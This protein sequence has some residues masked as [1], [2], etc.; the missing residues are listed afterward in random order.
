MEGWLEKNIFKEGTYFR[1]LYD[2]GVCGTAPHWHSE[3]EIIYILEGGVRAGINSHIYDL[4]Q[5]D[6]FLIG[7]GDSHYF[8]PVKGPGKRIV[9]Q[10][11]LSIFDIAEQEIYESKNIKE[12]FSKVKKVSCSWD[13]D[14]K[15]TF[16]NYIKEIAEEYNKKNE[17]YMFAIRA[18]IYD[19]VA[20]II[21]RIPKES[22][23]SFENGSHKE[24]LKR[25][26]KVIDYV[27]DNYTGSLSLKKASEAAGFSEYY[28]TRFFKKYTGISFHK[29]LSN[30]RITKAEWLLA[31]SDDGITQVV[32]KTG[33]ASIKTFN[34]VFKCTKG[35]SPTE[36]RREQN[37]RSSEQ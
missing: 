12:L 7:S 10:F 32:Y 33:F 11:G 15:I 30:F 21:R 25:L 31:N 17:G 29:Y 36:Y 34:K 1:I 27:N 19:I 3:I 13:D 37:M 14:V 4:A 6:I 22:E 28:F 2:D 8:F 26:E 24:N 35:C 16:E 5:G 18:R 9:I 20:L 23:S